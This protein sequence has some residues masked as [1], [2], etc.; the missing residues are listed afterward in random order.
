VLALTALT[1]LGTGVFWHGISFI[2][3]HTY[4][5]DQTRNLQL[6][7]LMGAV[8]TAGAFGAGRLTRAAARWATPR[9]I[10]VAA[11]VAQTLLCLG[12]VSLSGEWVLWVTVVGA[13]WISSVIWPLLESYLTAGRHG[14]SM[15]SAIGWFNLTWAPF[16]VIPLFAM[17][18]ILGT[19]GEWAIGG[20]AGA[21]VLALGALAFFR[22]RPGHHDPLL[23]EAS[24]T[25]EYPLLLR[26]ARVLLPL[27]YVLHSAM[28]P[29]LPYRFEALGVAVFWE[30][31]ATATWTVVRLLAF[32]VLWRAAFW[33]GRWGTLLVGAVSMTVGFGLVVAGPTLSFMLA[34]F[35]VMG[36]GV[37]VVYYAALYYAMSVGRAQVEAGGTH[38]GLIG[39][40]YAV[41]PIAGLAGSSP[42][43]LGSWAGGGGI[44]GVVWTIIGIAGVSA[45]RPYL[46]AR[47]QRTRSSTMTPQVPPPAR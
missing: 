23:A 47:R 34:G 1:S 5:F 3:K 38:E 41:G 30:T 8:Y 44:V 32:V 19:H 18:P 9:T 6:Y 7:A 29:I 13:T 10:L 2:A 28:N 37:G 35:A 27:S 39:A 33:H 31:P 15:R 21:N 22:P 25:P 14:S 24:V 16:V 40:G 17:A 42:R 4:G 26:S 43:L 20:F 12:P 46:A 45:F 11:C 36:A